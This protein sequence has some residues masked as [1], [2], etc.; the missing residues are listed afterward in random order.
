MEY[1]MGLQSKYFN[2]IKKSEKTVE[3]RL[4]DAKRQ[5]LKVGDIIE[6]CEEPDRDNKIDTI[7]VELD[8]Y[9]SF[10]DAIDGKGIKCFTNED[11]SSYLNDLEKY[12][13]KDKQEENGVLAITVSKVEKREKSCGAVVFKNINDKLHVLLIHHN[14]GH[15]GIPKG[16]VE[17]AEDEVETAK[18]E[19]LEE[20]GIETEVIPGFREIITYSPKKNVLKDVIF[21]IGKSLSDNLTPQLEEVQ[22][23]GFIPV[24]RALEII[25]YAEEKDILEKAIGYIEKNNLKY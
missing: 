22:E 15:W 24:D 1:K 5:E 2:L 16:H 3:A 14:L 20:T 8:K 4:N 25:T 18:R 23:V 9:N 19:V 7:V 6:F 17:G 12:Y 13:P 11:E 10:S 21:F